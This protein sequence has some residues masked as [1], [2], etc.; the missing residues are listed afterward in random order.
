MSKLSNRSIWLGGKT[1]KQ[2]K[3]VLTIRSR[4]VVSLSEGTEGKRHE[5]N[6]GGGNWQHSV[7]RL[8]WELGRYLF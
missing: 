5:E 7:S 8:R 1:R 2:S 4:I 6:F 3:E